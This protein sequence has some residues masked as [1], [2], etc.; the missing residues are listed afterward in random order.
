MDSPWQPIKYKSFRIGLNLKRLKIYSLS[1]ASLIFTGVSF[2]TT[3]TLLFHSPTS[4][5]KAPLGTSLTN[6]APLS[7]CWRKAS[8]LH[9]IPGSAHNWNG[10]VRLCLFWNLVKTLV[11]RYNTSISICTVNEDRGLWQYQALLQ[12]NSGNNLI[13]VPWLQ[14]L[15]ITF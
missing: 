10:C 9:W 6:A 12:H 7:T 15:V 3:P 8:P 1:W 4:P 13:F 5:A 14:L 2:H 11:L